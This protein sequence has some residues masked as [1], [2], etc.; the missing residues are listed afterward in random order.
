MKINDL[1]HFFK[2]QKNMDRFLFTIFE[3]NILNLRHE[4][5]ITIYGFGYLLEHLRP[6]EIVF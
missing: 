4:K 1:Y 5:T 3:N 2:T 6:K